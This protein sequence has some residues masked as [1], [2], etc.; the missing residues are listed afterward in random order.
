MRNLNLLSKIQNFPT[1]INFIWLGNQ[2]TQ[3]SANFD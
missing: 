1:Q 2:K 3:G